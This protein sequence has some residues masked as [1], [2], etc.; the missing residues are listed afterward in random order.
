MEGG[1]IKQRC[2]EEGERKET[3]GGMPVHT[4][5]WRPS[6]PFI[7]QGGRSF[8]MSHPRIHTVDLAFINF[9]SADLDSSIF[10]SA[11]AIGLNPI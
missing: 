9:I 6:S 1:R 3:L 5:K 2:R 11:Y 4:Q 10:I 7:A 8:D